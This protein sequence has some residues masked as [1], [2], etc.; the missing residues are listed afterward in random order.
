[1]N[2]AGSPGW[3]RHVE[4]DNRRDEEHEQQRSDELGDIGRGPT[5][6]H[7]GH[8]R[9]GIHGVQPVLFAAVRRFLPLIA[10]LA[11]LG[12]CGGDDGGGSPQRGTL[13]LDFQPNAVHAGIYA[14][15][16]IRIRVPS[17]STDS[18]KLLAAGRADMSVVDIHDLGLARE[19]GATSWASGRW[20]SA[21]SRR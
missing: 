3:H 21:R 12:G 18:L 17:A 2:G 4:R 1:M 10:L 5:V 8:L 20:C 7:F 11:C 19:R 9:R 15:D 13:A 16:N 14:A 6:L